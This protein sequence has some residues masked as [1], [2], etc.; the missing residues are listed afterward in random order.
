MKNIRLKWLKRFKGNLT[1]EDLKEFNEDVKNNPGKY[2]TVRLKQ[3]E[4]GIF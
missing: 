1:T 4:N 3:K 2:L